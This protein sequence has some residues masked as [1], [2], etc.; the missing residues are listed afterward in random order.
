MKYRLADIRQNP[1]RRMDRYPYKPEK[2][3]AL[4]ESIRS[5]GFWDNVVGRHG[6]LDGPEIAYGHH[7]LEA[8]IQELGPDY[9]ID[10]IV[11]DL[12]DELMIKIMAAE[13]MQEWG[14]SAAV[15]METV[16]V[17]V[18][19]YAAE[20]I[21]LELPTADTPGSTVRFAP[22]F[23]QNL[24]Q[25]HAEGLSFPYTSRSVA[26]FLGWLQPSGD[27]QRRVLDALGALELIE[28]GILAESDYEGLTSA[29]AAALTQQARQARREQEAEAR[30]LE[31]QARLDAEEAAAA[32]IRRA[33]AEQARREREAEQAE[34]IRVQ[35]ERARELAARRAAEEEEHWKA[36]EA[37]RDAAL[38]RQQ[39]NQAAADEARNAADGQAAVTGRH[40]GEQLRS[41]AIGTRGARAAAEEV[42]GSA[43]PQKQSGAYLDSVARRAAS[44]IHRI[45]TEGEL[46]RLRDALRANPE[47]IPPEARFYL[48]GHLR[49]LEGFAVSFRAEIE[50]SAK[51]PG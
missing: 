16:R 48:A 39:A 41:G 27:P 33:Q 23:I 44:H 38:A 25:A 26:E 29:Q 2:I 7:R 17:V 13:N 28:A 37:K 4:R 34:A 43:Q 8:A 10:L 14:T 36:A 18:E 3:T 46:P 45:I 42:K 1:F 19:A 24:P 6:S 30:R 11:R 32:E 15:E 35:D 31:E 49:H 5:T 9:Q 20:R 40:V 47:D 51:V 21:R 12:S 22:S 50:E